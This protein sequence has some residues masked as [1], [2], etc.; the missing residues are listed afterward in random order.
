[1]IPR[2]TILAT[3]GTDGDIFPF[4]SLA[5]VLQARGHRVT[6][7]T[8]EHFRQRTQAAD[9]GFLSLVS[10][11]ENQ[12]L[13]GNPD[14]WNP[15]RSGFVLARWGTKMLERQYHALAGI[16]SEP[17]STLVASVGVLAARLLQERNG[18]P[19]AGVVLQP[20]MIPS[21]FE[22]PVMMVG[23][24]LPKWTPR[25]GAE[26]YLR[27]WDGMG[28]LLVGPELNRVRSTIGLPPVKRVFQWWNS[29]Q[30]LLGLF[31]DWYAKPQPDWP[32]QLVLTGFPG[33]NGP[34]SAELDPETQRFCESGSAPVVFTFGTGMMHAEKL[35]HTSLE[36]CRKLGLRA[37]VLTKFPQ[38]LPMPLPDWVHHSTFAP[39]RRLF[40][41]CAAVVHHGGIGTTSDVLASGTPQLI[42][43]FAFDQQDNGCRIK[44]LGVG[45]WLKPGHR[46][47]KAL[48]AK[49]ET[50]MTATTRSNALATA[51]R[52][53]SV[54]GLATAATWIEAL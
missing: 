44:R 32:S 37:I 29:P 19:L 6:L 30:R 12:E 2:H 23:P 21:R 17:G 41:L 47:V 16:S 51:Q 33:F 46:T 43:P 15:L 35:F 3:L 11:H 4:F 42:L 10:E 48:T 8:H 26:L 27:A 14:M 39:F 9:L 18:T 54:D 28:S 31:P 22:P 50:I 36:A 25:W 45:D 40:P 5:K 20:W 24:T 53:V 13:L 7:A 34:S 38:Q 52:F 49:L 1:M